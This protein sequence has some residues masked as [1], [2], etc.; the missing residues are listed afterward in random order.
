MFPHMIDPDTIPIL[1]QYK[2]SVLG[3]K[4]CGA[5]GGGYWVFISEKTV[6]GAFQ[7]KIRRKI[8]K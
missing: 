3:W 7:I 4:L 8:L 5:G 6:T 2:D 1:N